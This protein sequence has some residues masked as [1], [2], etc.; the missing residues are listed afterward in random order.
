VAWTDEFV[1]EGRSWVLTTELGVVPKDR[2]VYQAPSTFAGVFLDGEKVRLPL[3]FMREKA[4]PKFRLEGGS[5]TP[6]RLAAA[7][8]G[9]SCDGEGC[10]EFRD[11][12]RSSPGRL[13]ETT[14]TWERL[15]HVGLTGRARWQKNQRYFETSDGGRWIRAEDATVV[16]R[17]APYGLELVL[18]EKWVDV[19]IYRG[20]LVAYEG[21]K[22]VFATLIS[23]GLRG[24]ARRNG[25]PTK[26]TTPTGSFRLEWKHLSTT[27]SPNP[28]TMSYFL[29]E[30]PFTQFFHMPFALHAAYWHDRFGEPR[31]GG[32]V[33]LSP[34][35]SKWLFEWTEPKLPP[36]WH[37]VR[38]GGGRGAGTWVRIR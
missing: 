6:F 33:N 12:P 24:Y 36:G 34:A 21:D 9:S 31:S 8:R 13:M 29:S 5:G 3:A 20:T 1:A 25:K 27:M 17:M 2:L 19:S 23:P 22:P 32:C 15:A 35:D 37:G 26:N 14:E 38:S 28:E 30:V 16:S 7:R 11:D 4:R 18:H 10:D